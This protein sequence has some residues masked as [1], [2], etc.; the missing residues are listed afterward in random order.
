M[1]TI[2]IAEAGINHN[3][4]LKLAK[5]LIL[6]ASKA[7]ADY[8][9]FQTYE[10]ENMIKPNTKLADYQKM[11]NEKERSQYEMLKK[12][13]LKKNYYEKLIKY[14]KLKKIKFLSSPFDIESIKFLKKFNLEFI[15]IPSGEINNYPYLKFLGKLNKKIILSTGMSN[16]KEVS[17]AI[18]ILIRFGTKKNKISLLHCHSDYPS[19]PQNLNLRAIM[20][21]KKKFNLRVGY[22]DHSIGVEASIAS[23]ALGATII[24]KHLTLNRKMIGPD[25]KA[26]M[27]PKNFE[28]MVLAIRNAEKMLGNGKKIPTQKELKNQKLVRKSIVAK[29][30]IS[31]GDKFSEKNITTKRPGIGISPMK[32]EIFLKKFAKKKYLKNDYI[33]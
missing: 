11:N 9:K 23:I 19:E 27:E 33:N 2:I 18:K 16:L 25:H 15:K 12:Y 21:L 22:S 26:S 4:N 24:E 3:G 6:V 5:K 28:K 32:Y 8:I 10:P 29:F 7:G 14:S 31:K 30:N 13:Q 20:T 1:K 17:D